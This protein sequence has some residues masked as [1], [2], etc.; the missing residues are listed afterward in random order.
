[1]NAIYS[2]VISGLV[3]GFGL[4]ISGMGNPAKVLNFLDIAGTWD[5]SLAF[6]IAGAVLV[7]SVGYRFI[8]KRPAPLFAASFALPTKKDIDTPLI[9]GAAIFGVGWGLGGFCPAPAFAALPLG[10]TGTLA[11]VPAI[12]AGMW[13]ARMTLSRRPVLQTS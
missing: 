2:A 4:V 9:S 5:P 10:E 13:A 11:F 3:F 1:M 12:L 6:V 8:L 7:T